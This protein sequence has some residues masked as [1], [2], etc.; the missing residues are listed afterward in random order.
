MIR[1]P[2]NMNQ[3]GGLDERDELLQKLNSIKITTVIQMPF[4]T[5]N[6]YAGEASDK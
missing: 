6:N 3:V 1:V 2:L 4:H 5:K